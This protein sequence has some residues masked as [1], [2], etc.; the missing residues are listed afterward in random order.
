MAA[1]AIMGDGVKICKVSRKYEMKNHRKW[2]KVRWKLGLG[3]CWLFKYE[4]IF[5]ELEINYLQ[6][7]FSALTEQNAKTPRRGIFAILS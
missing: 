4:H 7:L 5:K 6:S 1:V 3:M 2:Q